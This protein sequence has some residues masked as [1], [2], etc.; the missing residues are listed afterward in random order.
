VISIRNSEYLSYITGNLTLDKIMTIR[1]FVLH[2]LAIGLI[3][4]TGCKKE[5]IPPPPS[6]H[7]LLVKN[8]FI[9]L[10]KQQHEIAVKRIQKVRALSPNNEFLIQMEERELCNYYIK[11]AQE[12]LDIGDIDSA[13]A[14]IK[15]ALQQYALNRNLLSIQKELMTLKEIKQHIELMNAAATSK[16]MNLQINQI[17]A[18]IRNYPKAKDLQPMLRKKVL[19]AFKM[20]LAEEKRARFDLLCD[21]KSAQESVKKDES[22][23]QTLR[24]LLDVANSQAVNK[25]DRVSAEL[26]D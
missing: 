1:Y 18:C 22:L 26:L 5:E 16:D 14:E 25:S 24:A 11:K 8:L 15:K 7:T 17:V 9:N 20:K 3:V 2:I 10:D 19:E 13:L 6:T 23:N 21:L 12:K 4:I